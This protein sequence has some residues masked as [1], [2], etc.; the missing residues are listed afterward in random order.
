MNQSDETQRAI[1]RIEG[2][3]ATN[4]LLLNDIR[5]DLLRH[6]EDDRRQFEAVETRV[7]GLEKKVYWFS[8]A[9]AFIAFIATKLTGK[10]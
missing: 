10:L 1:G 7:S 3:L 5:N 9:F 2:T 4:T 8:G 6:F